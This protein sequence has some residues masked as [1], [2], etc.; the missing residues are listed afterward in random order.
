M[1]IKR[2][3]RPKS[4]S[5]EPLLR[6]FSHFTLSFRLLIDKKWVYS[7]AVLILIYDE[8][9]HGSEMVKQDFPP[10]ITIRVNSLYFFLS[11]P[12]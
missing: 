4:V 6:Y 8:L 5:E 9:V 2:C 1:Q 12:F 7:P 11:T 3:K 10:C